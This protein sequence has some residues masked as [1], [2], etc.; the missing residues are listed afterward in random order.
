MKQWR[1]YLTGAKYKILVECNLKNLEHFQ[2][3]QALSRRQARWAEILSSYNFVVEHLE[4]K[5]NKGDGPS[6]RPDYEI[7]SRRQITLLLAA[8]GATVEPDHNLLPEFQTAQV[9]EWLATSVQCRIV[10]TPMVSLPDLPKKAEDSSKEWE[11]ITG[12]LT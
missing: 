11:V 7:G 8:L 9:S 4:G 6:R 12:A 1:H 5:K 2:N 10:G 3:S